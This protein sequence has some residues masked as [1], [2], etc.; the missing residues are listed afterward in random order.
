MHPSIL[1]SLPLLALALGGFVVGSSEF[2][3]MGLLPE[4]AADL[5]VSL[6]VS[7][8]NVFK[9]LFRETLKKTS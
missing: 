7:E 9:E 2:I 4:V 3:I 8:T 1:L 6:A 5:G